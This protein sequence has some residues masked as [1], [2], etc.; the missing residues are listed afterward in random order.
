[1]NRNRKRVSRNAQQ[2]VV[3]WT[4]VETLIVMSIVML[5]TS[6]VGVATIRYVE[7][8]RVVAVRNQLQQYGLALESY[9]I[10]A[11]RYPTADQ[12]L[13]A[14]WEKPVV[15]P[16]P[17]DWDGPYINKPVDRDPWGGDYRYAVP[18][19]NGLPFELTS[20]G[21]DNAP[22]GDGNDEDISLSTVR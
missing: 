18:G 5:L 4:F 15:E 6:A 13:G 8:A 2:R 9:A 3:A 16:I 14:L 20:Y 21:A 12:G 10:D 19:P 1:M 17:S 7:R 22:G 11:G